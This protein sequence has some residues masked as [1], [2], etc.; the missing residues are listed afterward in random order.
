MT[1]PDVMIRPIVETALLEDL[2][3]GGDATASLMRSDERL[4]AKFIARKAGV[5][6]GLDAARIACSLVDP[7]LSFTCRLADGAPLEP[8]TVLA[9]IAGPAA[10][11]LTVERTAL[12][13][14]THLS[15]VASLTAQYVQAVVGTRAR[16]A[17][18]RKTLPGLRALQ[19]AAV[20]AGGGLPHRYGL[21][22]A[23]LI[24]DNHIAA[25]GSVAEAL[26]RAREAAGH[27]RVIEVEVDDLSQ[28]AE[29]L[30][31]DPDIVLL[32]N[33]SLADLRAAVALRA[34]QRTKLEAS[35]GVSLETVRAIAETGID[36]VSVGALTHS[37]PN[38]DIGLDV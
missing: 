6:A 13:F 12:N 5:A 30:P 29:A 11:V 14:L 16:I 20:V 33:F 34:E 4:K 31:F 35:G 23:I 37:A 10:S 1:L 24:K 25:C 8:H 26:K 9:D 32:D 17:A 38:L 2:G 3:R 28:L 7:T 15:G 21:D 18:T 22:D 36:V 27:M 19:K